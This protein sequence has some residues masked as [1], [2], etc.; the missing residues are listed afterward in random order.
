[1]GVCEG[2][3]A[4]NLQGV[5]NLQESWSKVSQAARGLAKAFPV[6]FFLVPI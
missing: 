5:S 2:H 3:C 1:M 4:S 6:T